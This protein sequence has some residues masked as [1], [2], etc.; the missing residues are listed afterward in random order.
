M[1]RRVRAK[2]G[3][4]ILAHPFRFGEP[5]H[6]VIGAYR[7]NGVETQ[8]SNLRPEPRRRAALL[9]DALSLP[10][11]ANS[12]AHSPHVLGVCHNLF[13]TLPADGLSL[14]AAV[15]A[16][17]GKCFCDETAIAKLQAD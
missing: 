8:S 13:D 9:A 11:F 6:S 15:R 17:N 7:P 3:A 10:G 14:A 12:D 16:F 2:G 5:L 1:I 4:I